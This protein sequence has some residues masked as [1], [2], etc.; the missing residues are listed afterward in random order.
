MFPSTVSVSDVRSNGGLSTVESTIRRFVCSAGI[1]ILLA[2]CAYDGMYTRFLIPR[3]AVTQDQAAV[4]DIMY[5]VLKPFG[6][7]QM[8][9]P[10]PGRFTYAGTDQRTR[11]VTVVLDTPGSMDPRN[12]RVDLS[13]LVL[14]SSGSDS[15]IAKRVREAIQDRF[16]AT[17]KLNLNFHIHRHW[18]VELGP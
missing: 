4:S 7:S 18:P 8:R 11:N 1:A 17:Y 9:S 13:I 5:D 14:D 12:P 3:I 6:F 10:A 15:E 16:T 2:G